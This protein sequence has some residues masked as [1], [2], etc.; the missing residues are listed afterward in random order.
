MDGGVG[1]RLFFWT[2]KKNTWRKYP[3]RCSFL[4]VLQNDVG[5]LVCGC[6]VVSVCVRMQVR[7]PSWMQ[8]VD[9]RSRMKR[10]QRMPHMHPLSLLKSEGDTEKRSLF[11]FEGAHDAYKC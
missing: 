8:K 10:E 5:C 1:C 7:F 9:S 6:C 11:F 4:D 3:A 2:V